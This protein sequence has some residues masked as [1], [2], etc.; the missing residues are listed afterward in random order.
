MLQDSIFYI[1]YP[2][3]NDPCFLDF[4]YFPKS[5]QDMK[6]YIWSD[7]IKRVVI[8]NDTRYLLRFNEVD[9]SIGETMF[10]ARDEKSGLP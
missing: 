9:I 1:K 8:T 6:T 10:F 5:G 3:E 2:S 7:K 4:R